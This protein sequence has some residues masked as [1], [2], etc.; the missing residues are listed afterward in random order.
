MKRLAVLGSTLLVLFALAGC[1]GN[2]REEEITKALRFFQDVADNRSSVTRA[3]KEASKKFTP[4]H[5]LTKE[6]LKPAL[7]TAKKLRDIG[8][9]LVETRAQ[10]D[11]LQGKTDD[12]E[13]E[14]LREERKDELNRLVQNLENEEKNLDKALAEVQ[15]KAEAEAW[16]ELRD[17]INSSREEMF[18]LT[19]PRT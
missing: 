17:A 12:R 9:Q 8:K 6:D 14:R 1:G 11:L 5:K 2:P 15:P 4:E 10:I 3:I 16:R 13:K 18:I 7:D 19:K